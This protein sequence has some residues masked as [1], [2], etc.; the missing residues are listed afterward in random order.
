MAHGLAALRYVRSSCTRNRNYVSWI[1]SQILHL[2]ATREAPEYSYFKNDITF[3]YLIS[4]CLLLKFLLKLYQVFQLVLQFLTCYMTL[5]RSFS[6]INHNVL[7]SF[8]KPNDHQEARRQSFPPQT[9][10]SEKDFLSASSIKLLK[11]LV[12]Q[13]CP[14]LR[15]HEL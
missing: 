4:A 2:W 6:E 9:Y 14:T 15:P 10:A 5:Q 13:S 3:G 11:V 7:V 1:G 12:A 8:S